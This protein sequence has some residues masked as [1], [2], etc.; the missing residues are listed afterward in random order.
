VEVH[1]HPDL[2]HNNKKF[3]EYFLEFLM[4][5]LA[6]TLGFIAENVRERLTERSK[7]KQYIGAFIRNVKDDADY[8]RHVITFDSSQ[9]KGLDSLLML[10]HANL[11]IDSNRKSFYYYVFRYCFNSAVFKSNDATLQQLKSS[12][13]YRLIDKDHV[14]DSL[15]KYDAGVR[16]IY[17][18]GDYYQIYFGEILSR[19]DDLGDMTIMLDSSYMKD[20]RL[21][22]KALPPLRLG[23]DKL[24][25]FF[26]KVLDFRIITSSY[27]QNDLKPQL[28]YATALIS[29][30][31]KEYGIEDDSQAD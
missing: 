15:S 1:H 12:G 27:S 24:P 13:D 2:H 23:G 31:E 10:A 17:A 11:T 19:I 9:V 5:F 18:Q 16:S 25:T 22:G 28:E 21:T 29:F 8:L 20:W 30:L 3:K 7:E 26:N 6:V 14:A 4:I